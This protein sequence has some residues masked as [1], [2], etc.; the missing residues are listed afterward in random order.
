M[1]S[2]N[3]N[4]GLPARRK[5]LGAMASIA[6]VSAAGLLGFNAT[7]ICE[8]NTAIHNNIQH[9]V[10]I[11]RELNNSLD[12]EAGGLLAD[13]LRNLYAFFERRL[14]ESNLKKTRKG[15]EE[16]LPML[17]Q[18]RDAWFKMLNGQTGAAAT[19]TTTTGDWSVNRLS[20]A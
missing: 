1:H 11:I 14:I 4:E 7:D 20:P 13:T 8:R 6:G 12:L 19:L 17:K 18:L 2:S 16:V 15:I 9:A 3:A 5:L 10:D